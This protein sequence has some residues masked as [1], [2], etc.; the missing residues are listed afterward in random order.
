MI[1]PGTLSLHILF[2]EELH[3]GHFLSGKVL[4]RHTYCKHI[5]LPATIPFLDSQRGSFYPRIT[6]RR[7]VPENTTVLFIVRRELVAQT[8]V[9][10]GL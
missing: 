9:W 6:M 4:Q 10:D 2:N 5:Y 8:L 3:S 1:G 7:K